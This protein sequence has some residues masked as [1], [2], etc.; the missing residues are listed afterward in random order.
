MAG[1]ATNRLCETEV[2]RR[3]KLCVDIEVVDEIYSFGQ[4]ML[5]ETLENTKILDSKAAS[6]AAYGGAIVTLLVSTSGGWVPLGNPWTLSIAAIAAICGFGAAVLAVMAMAL[7]DF[8]WLGEE[9]WLE[10]TCLSQISKLKSYRILTIWG[11]M[12]SHKDANVAKVCL[13]KKSQFWLS[14]S[15]LFVLFLLLHI[16]WLQR[17]HLA[18]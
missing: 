12:D 7:R 11:A 14:L 8:E 4:M 5:R 2:R 18:V 15:V 6:M 9:E 3:L 10:Q 1:Q 17:F 13:L 16:G